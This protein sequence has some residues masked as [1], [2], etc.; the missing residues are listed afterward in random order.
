MK[1]QQKKINYMPLYVAVAICLISVVALIVVLCIPEKEPTL[2]EFVPPAF[3][4]AAVA[5]TPTVSDDLGYMECYQDGMGFRFWACGNVLLDGKNANV[6]LTNPEGNEVWLKV[7]ILD[8]NGNILGESGLLKPGEY[9]KSVELA[10]QLAAGTTI[11]L[12]I[13]A[14]EPDTYYS[15][16]S[17]VL[18]TTIGGATK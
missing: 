4:S 3:D 18:N 2:G 7:R 8:A 5:G 13:M 17:V 11:K 6:Y 1:K 14:Y 16:G 12:K 9:V 15:A 10:K